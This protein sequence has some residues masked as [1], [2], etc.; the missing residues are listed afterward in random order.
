LDKSNNGKLTA[1]AIKTFFKNMGEKV[2]DQEIKQILLDNGGGDGISLE[3]FIEM[4][5]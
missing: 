4:Y 5:V 3:K 1:A 2:S